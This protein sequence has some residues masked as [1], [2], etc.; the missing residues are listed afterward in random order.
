MWVVGVGYMEGHRDPLGE[1]TKADILGLGLS[2]VSGVRTLQTYVIEG[3]KRSDAERA[4]SELLADSILQY[5]NIAPFSE[6]GKHLKGLVK[7]V[8]RGAWAI[9]VFFRPGVMDVA[10]LSVAKAIEVMGIKNAKVRTGTTYII[11]GSLSEKDVKAVCE[12][13]LAN[14]LIQTYDYR[15]L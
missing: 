11:E 12:K 5:F 2:K 8:R 9:E 7:N 14:K 13:C 6:S 3:V 15:K 4:G 10:G 1:N